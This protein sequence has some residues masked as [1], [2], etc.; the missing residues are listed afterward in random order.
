MYEDIE[1][2]LYVYIYIYIHTRVAF[3][4]VRLLGADGSSGLRL[5]VYIILYV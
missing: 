4:S 3:R 2:D 5:L 1:I